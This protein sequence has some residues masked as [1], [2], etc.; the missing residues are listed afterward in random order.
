MRDWTKAMAALLAAVS[1][2]GVV[3]V[4]SA[5]E[6]ATT[7]VKAEAVDPFSTTTPPAPQPQN[8][9]SDLSKEELK[10]S[11]EGT[12]EIHVSDANL[13]DLLR[14]L[15]I[16]TKKNILTSKSVGGKVTANL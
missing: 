15:S 7:A 2:V 9:G 1:S 11:D 10:V 16:Q 13:I 5:Q 8:A 12:V 14:T 3:Q 4:L 6:A